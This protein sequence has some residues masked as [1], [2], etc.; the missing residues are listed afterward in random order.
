[1]AGVWPELGFIV[2]V[3]SIFGILLWNMAV[4][5]IGP[6]SAGLIGNFAPVITYLIALYQG[7]IPSS[8]EI[9]GV[10]LVLLALIAN[11][12]HQRRLN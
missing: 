11:N 9:A 7:R 6:L 1:M 4:A 5:H 3:V 8:G 12:R 10:L 2:L